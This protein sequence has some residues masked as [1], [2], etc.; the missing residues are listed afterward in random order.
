MPGIN[1]S[2]DTAEPTNECAGLLVTLQMA[3]IWGGF[4]TLDQELLKSCLVADPRTE[5]LVLRLLE[6][7][8]GNEHL[9][10]CLISPLI[11]QGRALG[12]LGFFL[13][14]V[15]C[16]HVSK[17]GDSSLGAMKY[18][19][20]L[21][22]AERVRRWF[23][24][25][26]VGMHHFDLCYRDELVG[27][28]I[29]LEALDWI[30]QQAPD[31]PDSVP[32]LFWTWGQAQT[33]KRLCILALQSDDFLEDYD[34]G[35]LSAPLQELRELLGEIADPKEKVRL[36]ESKLGLDKPAV[37]SLPPDLTSEEVEVLK[38]KAEDDQGEWY[39]DLASICRRSE[40]T[41][42]LKDW[43]IARLGRVGSAVGS[44][45]A[46]IARHARDRD[47]AWVALQHTLGEP[48]RIGL[49][50][51]VRRFC[52]NE[53]K[54]SLH[55]GVELIRR[56]LAVENPNKLGEESDR[57]DLWLLMIQE[58]GAHVR[59]F[60]DLLREVENRRFRGYNAELLLTS[61]YGQ[62][63]HRDEIRQT[64]ERNFT[65]PFESD[66]RLGRP[67]T[68]LDLLRTVE[69]PIAWDLWMK[70]A[71]QWPQEGG[72]RRALDLLASAGAT[73]PDF[74]GLLERVAHDGGEHVGLYARRLLEILSPRHFR[75]GG[76]KSFEGSTSAV[77]FRELA[78][79]FDS[80][81]F[82]K[83]TENADERRQRR[84]AG[85]VDATEWSVRE[86]C[87]YSLAYWFG[88]HPETLSFLA[89]YVRLPTGFSAHDGIE[90][91]PKARELL[92]RRERM[93]DDE[94]RLRQHCLQVLGWRW[95]ADERVHE[96]AKWALDHPWKPLRDEA[97]RILARDYASASDTPELLA[98]QM[99]SSD[100]VFEEYVALMHG[101]LDAMRKALDTLAALDHSACDY[102]VSHG[103]RLLARAYGP[104]KDLK[105][106]L[107]K[108]AAE[109]EV[110][111][112][113]ESIDLLFEKFW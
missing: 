88:D 40:L 94:P 108:I 27:I 61:L 102:L 39:S 113:R 78:D 90:A 107:G 105:T 66:P 22:G 21:G 59:D 70:A 97:S 34:L 11:E 110:R 19:D 83:W 35:K 80:E 67:L 5:I 87:A 32:L 64:V 72:R 9:D 25:K 56:G 3:S 2:R 7:S 68:S 79:G 63:R 55:E 18:L 52:R 10:D 31:Q 46:V 81:G 23:F 47:L 1:D 101:D 93:W 106:A 43:L 13:R 50:D 65:P 48:G 49:A 76:F 16:R 85:V 4:S 41:P 51:L 104:R 109:T 99:G 77:G 60:S 86:N 30:Y 82:Q 14:S 62:G 33:D 45:A 75:A 91:D 58:Y 8:E 71:E 12:A 84:M 42:E 57:K 15:A 37:W 69:S 20:K 26:A 73:K 92:R 74:I 112:L 95:S 98:R 96:V 54:L 24:T 111:A 53:W 100:V 6:F 89:D 103:P 44:W 28:H 17:R 36:C 29:V 38:Q